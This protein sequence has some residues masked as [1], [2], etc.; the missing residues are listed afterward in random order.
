MNGFKKKIIRNRK[1]DLPKNSTGKKFLDILATKIKNVVNRKSNF[2]KVIVYMSTILQ[3]SKDIKKAK[4]VKSL[5]DRQLTLWEKEDYT[6][7]VNTAVFASNTY[8]TSTPLNKGPNHVA[9]VFQQLL[10]QGKIQEATNYVINS[11]SKGWRLD[12]EAIDPKSRLRVKEVLEK[13]T[14]RAQ[15]HPLKQWKSMKTSLNS[16]M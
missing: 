4:D 15:N 13:N 7:L 2:K 5:L 11:S 14:H 3:K 8:K 6:T 16:W 10:L 12:L 9:Q 1:Y